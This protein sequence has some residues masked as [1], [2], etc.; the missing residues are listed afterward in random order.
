VKIQRPGRGQRRADG[1]E[2][3][4]VGRGMSGVWFQDTGSAPLLGAGSEAQEEGTIRLRGVA[5]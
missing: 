3:A 1:K 2:E 5:L 4:G